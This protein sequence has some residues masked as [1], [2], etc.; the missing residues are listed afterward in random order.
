MKMPSS[1][2]WRRKNWTAAKPGRSGCK[3]PFS[4][5]DLDSLAVPNTRTSE[6]EPNWEKYGSGPV[7]EIADLNDH[8]DIAIGGRFEREN[9]ELWRIDAA[10]PS[11]RVVDHRT[12]PRLLRPRTQGT[13]QW[14]R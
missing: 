6:G 11:E 10:S 7:A 12:P 3:I 4:H 2:G 14:M 13:A 5:S 9:R 8:D 1:G